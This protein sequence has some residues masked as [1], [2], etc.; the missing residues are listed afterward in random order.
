M[1][2]DLEKIQAPKFTHADIST[3]FFWTSNVSVR[4]KYLMEA[5]LFDEDFTE[6]GWEDIEFGHRLKRLGLTR[7]YNPKAL[8]YHFKKK[9][10]ASDLP[11]LCKQAQS[12]G[13]SAVIYV[14]KRP[15]LSARMSTGMFPLRFV[16]NDLMKPMAGICARIIKMAGDAPLSGLPLFC[17]RTLVSFDYFDSARASLASKKAH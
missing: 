8:V 11:R 14:S 5:G 17:A 12:S 7:K 15:C 6:Y 3:S 9:W 1:P 2:I 16:M 13:R 10:R 4:R